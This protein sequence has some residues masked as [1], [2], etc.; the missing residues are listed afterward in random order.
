MNQHPELPAAQQRRIAI[1]ERE[2]AFNPEAEARI[3]EIRQQK[4]LDAVAARRGRDSTGAPLKGRG[5]RR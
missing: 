5:K 2:L 4:R 1:A 3:A